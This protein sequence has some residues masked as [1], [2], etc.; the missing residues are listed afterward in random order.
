M[1]EFKNPPSAGKNTGPRQATLDILNA[2]QSRPGEWALIKRD[3]TPAAMTIWKRRENI[4]VRSSSI[5]KPKG[6]CDLYARW[7]GAES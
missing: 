2:L 4:E 7:I 1:I 3:V 5:G 6:K